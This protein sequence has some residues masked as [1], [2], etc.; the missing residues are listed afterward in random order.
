MADCE[1]TNE[2]IAERSSRARNAT[3]AADTVRLPETGIS[4]IAK[5]YGEVQ[6]SQPLPRQANREEGARARA[7]SRSLLALADRLTA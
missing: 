4:Q 6:M 5:G 7:M 2:I 3:L 1:G